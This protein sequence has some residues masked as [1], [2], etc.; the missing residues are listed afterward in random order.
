MSSSGTTEFRLLAADGGKPGVRVCLPSV[1]R[2][3]SE[4]ALTHDLELVL[5]VPELAPKGLAVSG[6]A[7]L[8]T[9][10]ASAKEIEIP[11]SA[12]FRAAQAERIRGE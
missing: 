10:L 8:R 4:P 11:W 6:I 12:F 3:G 2:G 9:D 5:S 1:D 7:H